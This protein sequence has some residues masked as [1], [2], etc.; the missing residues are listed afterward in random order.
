MKTNWLRWTLGL[1]LI[2][3]IVAVL[4]TGCATQTNSFNQDYN[5]HYPASPQYVIE[6]INDTEFKITVT[7]GSP[8]QGPQRVLYMKKAASII[9]DTEAKRRGWQEWQ[10]DYIQERDNGWMHIIIGDV[11]RQK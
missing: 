11:T 10:L 3:A 9:A 1:L 5:E 8:L 4:A 7:Q 6:N 2:N